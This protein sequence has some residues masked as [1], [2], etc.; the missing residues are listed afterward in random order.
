MKEKEFMIGCNYW[1]SHAGIYMW[2]KYD[3]IVTEKD[4][5][6][7][8]NYGVNTLRIFPLWCDFQPLTEVLF[9]D[10]NPE[11]FSSF[12]M[13]TGDKPLFYQKYPDSGLDEKQ[14][15]NFKHFLSVAQ[16]YNLKIIVSFITGWMSGSKF[17]PAPFVSKNLIKDPEVVLYEC[18]FINDLILEI[19]D[20]DNIIAYEPGNETNCLSDGLTEFDTEMWL[21]SIVDTIRLADPTRPVYSGMHGCKCW[22]NWNLPME[23]KRCDMVT[24]HPY[25]AF[26]P[27]CQNEKLTAMRAAMH[28]ASENSYYSSIAGVPSLVEEAGSLGPSFLCDEA[29]FDYFEQ[30]CMTSYMAGSTGFLWWCAFD[31]NLL[32]FDPYDVKC[33]ET[34]LGLAYS[35]QTAKPALVKLQEMASVIEEIGELESPQKDAVVVLG[36][37]T[38]NWKVAYGGFMLGVQSGYYLDFCYESQQIKDSEYYI[39][40]CVSSLFFI[41]KY[42]WEI[43]K[44]KV[45]NGAKLLI[46]ANGG[47]ILDFEEVVGLKVYG[48]ET[49]DTPLNFSLQGK[50]LSI[51]R[52]MKME[53]KTSTAKVLSYDDEGNIAL[54]ENTY[55]KGTVMF[56]NAPLEDSYTELHYPEKT[57]LYEVYKF[58]FKD[59]K[60]IVDVRDKY[61]FTTTHTLANGNT[62]VMLYN[63]NKETNAIDLHLEK[64]TKIEKVLYAKEKDGVLTMD[65]NY[66][67]IELSK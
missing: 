52:T 66:A 63:F 42:Q 7:L 15:E 48:N 28:S 35:N 45:R 25:P 64:G 43:L 38:N 36:K 53:L 5:Q 30:A 32:N 47:A 67:Y 44:E 58:F 21:K 3:K 2:R 29:V 6:L 46:S 49:T 14:V 24:T 4:L 16:K 9:C 34:R 33:V 41:P 39:L 10:D 26:T 60:K 27:Y 17:V 31:Q 20:F 18:A 37:Y 54:T 23:G 51:A 13:R 8:S 56:L 50:K 57:D 11:N 65:K 22:G 55:G 40:P 19:K 12:R 1:A 61:V 62:G 59:K